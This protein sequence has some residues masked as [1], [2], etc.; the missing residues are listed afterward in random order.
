MDENLMRQARDITTKFLERKITSDELIVE[1]RQILNVRNV[2]D[3]EVNG[4]RV[5]TVYIARGFETAIVDDNGAHP[6]ERYETY[7]EAILG[8]ERWKEKA[9]TLET[10][11]KLAWLSVPEEVIK[12][13]RT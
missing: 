8:H 5:S 6:V 10:I 11:T 4:L 7:E 12:L 3:E 13:K 1:L 2:L 9:K